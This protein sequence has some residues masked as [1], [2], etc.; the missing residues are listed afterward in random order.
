MNE[1]STKARFIITAPKCSMKLRSKAV[2]GAL[3][4]IYKQI[5]NYNFKIQCY[6]SVK[7]LWPVQT[8]QSVIETIIKLNS[9]N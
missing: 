3:K 5:E 7:T 4:L 6:S 1:S 8:N 9:R 2:T